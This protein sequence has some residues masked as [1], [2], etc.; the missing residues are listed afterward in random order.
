VLAESQ[1]AFLEQ[2]P[3]AEAALVWQFDASWYPIGQR[4]RFVATPAAGRE[5]VALDPTGRVRRVN[6]HFHGKIMAETLLGMMLHFSRGIDVGVQN[7]RLR[8]YARE[9]FATT[10]RLAGQRAL[11]IGYGPIGRH[12]AALLSAIGMRVTGVKRRPAVDLGP[13]EAVV[14]LDRLHEALST[15]HHVVLTLPGDT[16]THH[17]ISDQ[18]FRALRPGACLYNLG[19]GNAVDEAA[20]LRAL[21]TG[22][23]HRAFLDVTHEEPLPEGSPLWAAPGLA[24]LPHASAISQ[25]YLEL[26]FDELAS[27]QL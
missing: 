23:L 6:G 24:L 27:E 1:A 4:L 16:D 26:W 11:I 18:E 21:S 17:L 5:N 15:T 25:D 3:G 2:L 8:S 20:L 9:P 22:K 13:A 7:Q 12:C 19:R 14:T 10:H